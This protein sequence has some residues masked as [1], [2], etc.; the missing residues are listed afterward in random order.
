MSNTLRGLVV[1]SVLVWPLAVLPS[2][3]AAHEHHKGDR[4]KHASVAPNDASDGACGSQPDDADQVAAV[5]AMADEECDCAD[6]TNHGKYVHCVAEVADDAV[7]DGDL[8][9]ECR[10]SVVSCAT[11][12]TCGL[13]DAVTCCRTDAQGNT[14]CSIK[15]SAESCKAPR[16]GSACVG[17]V[18]SCCDACGSDGSCPSPSSTTTTTSAPTTT[19]SGPATTTTT[20][21]V[22]TTTTTAPVE[23]TTTTGPV[24]TTTT[25]GPV[26]TTTTT[27][28]VETTTTAAPV[29]TT[30][31]TTLPGSP[32]G[33]FLDREVRW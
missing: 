20:G 32:S 1:L 9:S 6:A 27:G 10:D 33:A 21:P 4:S 22:E 13:E 5:R 3:A 29:E 25:T 7:G 14:T 15:H 11:Q 23:T 16:G 12:S 8:R 2:T 30:T 19:T 28:P 18:P 31:T 26:E 17:Q 24:E